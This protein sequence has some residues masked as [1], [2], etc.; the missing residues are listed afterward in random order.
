MNGNAGG[1]DKY[2]LN[3]LDSV[4]NNSLKIDF[5]TNEIDIKLQKDLSFYG[6]TLYEISTLKHPIKQYRQVYDII[7]ENK[8]DV[9]YFNISTAINCIAAIAAQKCKVPVRILHSHASG[10]DSDSSLKKFI[11]NVMHIMCKLRLYKA[12][13]KFLACSKKAGYW[14]YPKRLV[15][16]EKL[17]IINNAIDTSL[18]KYDKEIRNS[19]RKELCI[20]NE[21]VIGFV[22]N[23]SYQK[24]IFFLLDVFSIICKQKPNCVLMLA[25]DGPDFVRAHIKANELN[26]NDKVLFLGRRKDVSSLMQAMDAFVLP[27]KSEGLGIV[28]IEA[29]ACG[30]RCIFSDNVPEEIKVTSNCEFLSLK[31]NK[32]KWANIIISNFYYERKD[33]TDSIKERG[34]DIKEQQKI[35][36]NILS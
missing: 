10:N 26:I 34:Y 3:F 11:L 23:F 18:F 28:G 5:L 31:E 16:A 24:N 29:Q 17:Q 7:K 27:S 6:C 20:E 14:L 19:I 2:L 32:E 1:I 22:G 25:G 36:Q 4:S 35:L 12:A 21:H 30:L 9:T 13:N 33:E 8:Y 15:K